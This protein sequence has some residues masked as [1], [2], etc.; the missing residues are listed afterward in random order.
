MLPH[1]HGNMDRKELFESRGQEQVFRF[2]DEL[3]E[4][5]RANL[6]SQAAEID[7]DELDHLVKTL[8]K[9]GSE[10]GSV[11]FGAL[12]PAPYVSIPENVDTDPEWQEAKR[13]GEEAIKA[14]KVAAFTVAG[15]QGTRLGYD[16]PKG[17]YPVTPVK[18]KT[19]FQVFA[20]KIQAVS[21]LR[22][23]LPLV[24]EPNGIL[25]ALVQREPRVH[26]AERVW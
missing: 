14:G 21:R 23:F 20:E 24:V 1:S 25:S 11:D 26:E 19:L 5:E 7:L 2:W 15:G 6:D 3:S 22:G 10:H 4:E 9:G 17:T 16:G 12:E 13:L 8:V 18:Q